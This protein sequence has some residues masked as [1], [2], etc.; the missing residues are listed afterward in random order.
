MRILYLGNDLSKSS[1]YHSAYATLK[2]NLRKE[3][4]QVFSASSKKNQIFRLLDM[5]L[6]VV[7]YRKRVDYILIDTFSTNAFYFTVLCSQLARVF[8]LKYIPILHG[9]NLPERLEK[10][11]FLSKL[12]FK[13]SYRNVAPSNYLKQAFLKKGYQSILI[14]NSINI[15]RYIFRE[16]NFLKPKLLYVR[17][18]A[19]IY[20]PI[21]AIRVFKKV[22]DKYPNA[23]LCMVGPDRDGT[24]TSVLEEIRLNK[25]ESKI[26]ITG[27]L[28][29]E[30]WHELS[31]NYDI[32]IN[33]TKVDNTPV[34]LIETMA[35]GIPIVTTDVGGIP[36]LME[37]GIDSVLVK[38]NNSEDMSNAIF[39]LLEDSKK[40]NLFSKKGREKAE[41][42]DWGIVYKQWQK[43]LE[44]VK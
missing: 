25:L 22:I 24:L 32:F 35:L 13:N 29:K 5:L 33:T 44:N 43:T 8:Q 39:S 11:P 28:P 38:S 4:Y 26:K 21:M 12:V 20:N 18:F 36:Y 1:K 6:C 23:E 42:M 19:K 30:E 40:A 16:R 37:N 10:S 31:K 27:V 34:S 15:K 2:H 14:P 9:G 41:Q 3:N 17:A 7:K